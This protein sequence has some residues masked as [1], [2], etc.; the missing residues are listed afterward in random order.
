[1][2]RSH[3]AGRTLHLIDV[4]NLVGGSAAGVDAVASALEAYRRTVTIG[5]DDH[6]VLGS[7]TELAFAANA[8]WPSALLRIGKGLDGADRALLSV[9]DPSFIVSH[10]HRLVVAS[11]DHAFAPMVAA[12]RTRQMAV[13]VVVRDRRSLSGELR[14]LAMHRTLA[15]AS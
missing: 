1:M 6:V 14:R 2:H 13:M 11:G 7:G 4:E 3:P 12:L 8:A 15:L 10:Y 5:P 9:L